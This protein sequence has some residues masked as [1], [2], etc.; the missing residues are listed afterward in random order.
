MSLALVLLALVVVG[1]VAAVATGLVTGGLGPA[2][3]DRASVALTGDRVGRLRS[4]DLDRVRFATGLRG[5]R[6]DE[7]D[8][9]L[10]RVRAE[11]E[12][13]DAELIELH[14]WV[15]ARTAPPSEPAPASAREA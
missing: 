10:D 5:Y 3:H 14:G 15:A 11:L 7:V 2:P 1:V 12:A 6:M 13:R 8:A 9:A 4:A